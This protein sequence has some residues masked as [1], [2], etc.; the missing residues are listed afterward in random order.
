MDDLS[1]SKTTSLVKEIYRA[2]KY[3]L[4]ILLISFKTKLIRGFSLKKNSLTKKQRAESHN[5]H[6]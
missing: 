3:F 5:V 4:F 1:Y 2:E 6:T